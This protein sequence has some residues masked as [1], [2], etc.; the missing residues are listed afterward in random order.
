MAAPQSFSGVMTPHD[1][2]HL[3]VKR[4]HS[5]ACYVAP[6]PCRSCG[7]SMRRHNLGS[8]SHAMASGSCCDSR[9]VPPCIPLR[10]RRLSSCPSAR[11][12]VA[13]NVV[14]CRGPQM[15]ATWRA[16][17]WRASCSS[18]RTRRRATW[19]WPCWSTAFAA[20]RSYAGR[21]QCNTWRCG[22]ARSAAGAYGE[23]PKKRGV[24][25]HGDGLIP[26]G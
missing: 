3:R 26:M 9:P 10:P 2:M 18:C 14:R 20:C 23:E 13:W 24:W 11:M 6:W 5:T 22:S 12:P 21:L 16:Q 8:R 7:V 19:R 15:E 17:G 1:S 25:F 4:R